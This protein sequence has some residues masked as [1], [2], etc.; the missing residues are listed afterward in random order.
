[1]LKKGRIMSVRFVESILINLSVKTIG[2]M[3]SVKSAIKNGLINEPKLSKL[4]KNKV[5]ENKPKS[6]SNKS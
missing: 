2:F 5:K 1:M 4:M 3:R 6:E